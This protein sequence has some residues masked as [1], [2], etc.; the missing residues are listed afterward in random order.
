MTWSCTDVVWIIEFMDSE[1]EMALTEDEWKKA[2]TELHRRA[3]VVA[4]GAGWYL[5]YCRSEQHGWQYAYVENQ[6]S[7]LDADCELSR[8]RQLPLYVANTHSPVRSFELP[9]FNYVA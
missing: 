3:G 2:S 8:C 7:L 4:M 1:R 5:E 6:C 9:C